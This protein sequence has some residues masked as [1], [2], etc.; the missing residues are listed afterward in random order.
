MSRVRQHLSITQYAAIMLVCLGNFAMADL[1][2]DLQAVDA[3]GV[4][5]HPKVGAAVDPANKVVIEGIALN[6]PDEILDTSQ[7]WQVYVQSEGMDYGGIAAFAAIFYDSNEWPRYPMDIQAGDRVRIE[8]YTAFHN[9]KTNINE[10]HSASPDLRFIVTKVEEGVGLPAPR[11]IAS[12]ASCNYFDPQRVG[13]GERY[14]DQWVQLNDV[15]IDSG[16]WAAGE[17]IT[18]SDTSGESLS[19]LLSSEGDFDDH[20]A[21]TG[22]FSVV[23]IF[24]QEDTESPFTGSYRLWV[25]HYS[26]LT[27]NQ[28]LT[29]VTNWN[30]Y[31]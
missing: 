26:D 8:G 3:D 1:P 29:V 11:I 12:I 17:T 31:E 18:I 7:M 23:G 14:Q 16:T 24:D 2:W 10:R 19:I 15:N 6:A 22:D 21:P 13:G 28:Q 4:A 20:P 25:K 30:L 27:L 5:T 9:G